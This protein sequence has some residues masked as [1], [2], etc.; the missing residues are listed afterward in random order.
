MSKRNFILLVI[1]IL[2]VIAAIFAFMYFRKTPTDT[3]GEDDGGTN[4]ISMFNPFGNGG[5]NPSPSPTPESVENPPP[6]PQIQNEKLRRVSSMPVAGYGV[7]RK[8]RL[9]E[10][11]APTPELVV[12]DGTVP[13]ANAVPVLPIAPSTEFATALRYVERATGNIYQTF[14]DRLEER[15]FTNTMLPKIYEAFFGN[16]ASVVV[17]RYLKIDDQTIS[18]FLGNVP[19][20]VLGA[21]STGENELKG[22]YL[23][24]NITDMSISPDSLKMF[25]LFNSGEIAVGNTLNFVDNKKTQVFDSPFTEW[26]SWW[27]KNGMVT[28]TTKP[29]GSV[30]GYIYAVDTDRKT[31]SNVFGNI[32]GLTTLTSPS[33]KLVLYNDNTLSLSVYNTDTRQ[34]SP[35]GLKTLAEKCVWSRVSDAVYCS[36]PKGIPNGEYPDNWYKGEVAF[37]DGIWKIDINTLNTDLL[38][39]PAQIAGD[40]IDGIKLSLDEKEDYLFLVNKKDSFLWELGL[41]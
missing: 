38:V 28:L 5:T 15:K 30:P 12:P 27:P 2:I 24:D 7:Y 34:T 35:L 41:R 39:D 20:E 9:T 26:L 16:N 40:Y 11:P 4:F 36:V 17:M 1:V 6:T 10:V 31:L 22:S 33:G 21:D 37:S 19:V 29:S 18:T 14:A 32:N 23:P 13:A 25:Y 8:E 3:G